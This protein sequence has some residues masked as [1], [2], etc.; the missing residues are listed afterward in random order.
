MMLLLAY[1]KTTERGT[2]ML[3]LSSEV[4]RKPLYTI[5]KLP[6]FPFYKISIPLLL[7]SYVLETVAS[8]QVQK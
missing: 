6:K 5:Q 8:V 7:F 4:L 1:I 2:A 3:H